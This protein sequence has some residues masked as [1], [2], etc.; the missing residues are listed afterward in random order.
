MLFSRHFRLDEF[1][2]NVSWT[3]CIRALG[4]ED[5]AALLFHL[6]PGALYFCLVRCASEV[7]IIADHIESGRAGLR[8]V[9]LCPVNIR[10]KG[11]R[12]CPAKQLYILANVSTF[13][14]FLTR[15]MSG[16]SVAWRTLMNAKTTMHK[17]GVEGYYP[18]SGPDHISCIAQHCPFETPPAKSC[19]VSGTRTF[20]KANSYQILL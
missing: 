12:N 5:P 3:P 10:P 11:V 1:P 2:R 15:T 14:C 19:V 20:I 13:P 4:E 7:M 16:K 18:V 8:R 6:P 9:P 17:D